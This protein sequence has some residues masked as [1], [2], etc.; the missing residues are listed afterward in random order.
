[1][2]KFTLPLNNESSRA[3]IE[4]VDLI[5]IL[6]S[7]LEAMRTTKF[8]FRLTN[9]HAE[10]I[11]LPS[12]DSS[13]EYITGMSFKQA[14]AVTEIKT[15]RPIPVSRSSRFYMF[16]RGVGYPTTK[17]VIKW[18]EP[19]YTAFFSRCDDLSRTM[20]NRGIRES[21]SAGNWLCFLSGFRASEAYKQNEFAAEY[22][23]QIDFILQRC[24]AE[25]EMVNQI[26]GL[27]AGEEVDKQ[28]TVGIMQLMQPYWQKFSLVPKDELLLF[29]NAL[30]LHASGKLVDEESISALLRSFCFMKLDFYL[31]LFASYEVGCVLTYRNEQSDLTTK[32]GLL[33]RALKR[34][35]ENI[36]DSK[37]S[38]CFGE[39]LE[40]I[41]DV[42][43]KNFGKL[44]IREMARHIPIKSDLSNPSAE[45]DSERCYNTLKAWR[46]GK[47]VPSHELLETFLSNLTEKISSGRNEQLILMCKMALGIDDMRKRWADELSKVNEL[48]STS[49]LLKVFSDVIGRYELYYQH[50]LELQLNKNIA[51]NNTGYSESS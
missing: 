32:K 37:I 21:S 28:D 30:T 22:R 10:G 45:T 4:D 26:R 2:T 6:D 42:I 5:S 3:S 41:R 39:L 18:I 50:H 23:V 13:I 20:V 40:E 33:C 29:V 43:S 36:D 15:G 7:S 46:K 27:I 8:K 44:S 16:N 47:E 1:M 35:S 9:F 51:G 34:F 38:T 49:P 19:L 25:L 12:L 17:K 48:K 11:F 14:L 24:E 31:N